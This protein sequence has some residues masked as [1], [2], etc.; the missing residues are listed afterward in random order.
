MITGCPF[1]GPG[2]GRL[3]RLNVWWMRLGIVPERIGLGP[4]EQN[5]SHEQFHRVLK[6]E[7]TRPPGRAR[8]RRNSGAST[9]SVANTTTIRPHEAFGR[10][11]AGDASI[12]RRRARC[13]RGCPP[14]EYPGPLGGA[15]RLDAPASSPGAARPLFLTEVLGG[16][17]VALEEVDDGA[18]DAVL[19][20]RCRLARFDERT[21]TL[22][23]LPAGDPSTVITRGLWKL[24]ELW[25]HNAAPTAPWKTTAQVFHSYHRCFLFLSCTNDQ[26]RHH[27]K[28]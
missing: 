28:P 16:E 13:R 19:R 10:S 17:H 20:D 5:G 6:A 9:P 15:P 24:P 26:T 18:L 14:L 21:R 8:A 25:T 3:S 7:T 12:S 27:R 4:P 1:A 11:A 22:T 2:L 23:A